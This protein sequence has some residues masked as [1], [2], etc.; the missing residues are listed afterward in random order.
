MTE[1]QARQIKRLVD[2]LDGACRVKG[3][4]YAALKK[5]REGDA[6]SINV[7]ANLCLELNAE[8]IGYIERD[9][10]AL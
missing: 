1:D 8:C 9:I 5:A 6:E 7:L 2:N 10:G 3:K 4:I